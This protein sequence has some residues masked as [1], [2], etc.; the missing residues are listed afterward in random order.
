MLESK[1]KSKCKTQLEKWGWKVVHLIQTNTNGI[2]DTMIMR[3]G[4]IVFIEFKQPGKEPEDDGLQ[5]YRI[6]KLK[7]NGFTAIVVTDL[8]QLESLR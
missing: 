4:Q 5:A 6:R 3:K 7:E 1:I 8:K 2:P